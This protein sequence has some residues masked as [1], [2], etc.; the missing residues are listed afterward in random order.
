MAPQPPFKAGSQ[1][2]ALD[3]LTE[4]LFQHWVKQN[5]VPFDTQ[6]QG[7][8]NY[9]MRGYYQGLQNGN[10]M[11][12]PS[13]VNANDG[14]PHFTDYY[15][16]PQHQTFSNESKFAGPMAPQWINGSQLAA[17]SGR[18]IADENPQSALVKLL[19]GR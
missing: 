16:T 5:N 2:T 18:I 7:P 15:K 10:P 3:P 4:L 17:P 19:M 12:R 14:R 9:D 13:E 8:T 1:N 6:A 11:A